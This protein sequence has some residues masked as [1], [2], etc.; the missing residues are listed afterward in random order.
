MYLCQK[1]FTISLLM[2]IVQIGFAQN[3]MKTIEAQMKDKSGPELIQIAVNGAEELTKLGEYDNALSLYDDAIKEAKQ[4]ARSARMVV[5]YNK[6]ELIYDHFPKTD[7]YIKE[8]VEALDFVSGVSPTNEQ[9]TESIRMLEATQDVALNKRQD[10]KR[11]KTIESFY[12]LGR[13][14]EIE[15]VAHMKK[16]DLKDFKK[17]KTEEA[18]VELE[19]L[20]EEREQ[21]QQV[22]QELSES[23]A[24]SKRLLS[25]R[26]Q[27]IERMNRDQA[28]QE[29]IIQ[30]NMRM[31][32]S[33]KF[34]SEL[35]SIKL[36][37]NEALIAH[38]ESQLDLQESQIQLQESE[39]KLKSSQQKLYGSLGLLALG[40]VGFVSWIAISTKRSNK[41]L[42]EKNVIIEEEKERSEKL[43]LNILPQFIA[44]ELKEKSKVT[45]RRLKEVTVLFTDFINFS[46]ISKELRP[47]E[48]IEALDECF[49]A[50]D[51]IISKYNIEKI[52]T[53]G[54]S[55]M[56]AGGVP[57]AN[58]SHAQDAINAALDM[59]SFLNEWNHQREKSGKVRFDARIGIH[60]G[61]IISGV[62]GMKKFAYDIWGDTVNVAARLESQSEAQRINISRATY[63]LVK[64]QY[65]FEKRGS[66]K[67]KNMNEMEMYYVTTKKNPIVLN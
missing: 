44:Q 17:L 31:I 33:L 27:L 38:Q 2:S 14:V 53:I 55:Y 18:F 25:R 51:Q 57:V 64:D 61:P 49:R 6:A 67:V 48:L 9:I 36:V 58:Q 28:Q 3:S 46:K 19:K 56:C 16:E 54:D 47:E 21:L 24:Q 62:V 30:Y 15:R 41:M 20:K 32:D 59:V 5:E 60:T 63:E 40:L 11:L 1:I 12:D 34:M 50:F 4:L 43:L 23:V 37:S 26:S 13:E 7:K 10:K 65:E 45:T 8:L 52:K 22:R 39:L 35:D 66:M 42:A 29:A